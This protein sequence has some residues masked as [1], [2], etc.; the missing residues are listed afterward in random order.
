MYFNTFDNYVVQVLIPPNIEYVEPD[1]NMTADKHQYKDKSIL[2]NALSDVKWKQRND[3]I[4]E[5]DPPIMGQLDDLTW[6]NY[7]PILFWKIILALHL[8]KRVAEDLIGTLWR[9]KVSQMIQLIY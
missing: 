1:L 8:L 4:K 9:R 5:K 2:N 6:I 7:N 3:S